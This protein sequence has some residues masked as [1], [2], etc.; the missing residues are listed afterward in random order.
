[1]VYIKRNRLGVDGGAG[2]KKKKRRKMREKC[3]SYGNVE[4]ML[5]R[6]KDESMEGGERED[7]SLIKARKC[8]DHLSKKR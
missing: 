5:T 3:S 8:R 7:Q 6:K 2:A 4:E 1:M